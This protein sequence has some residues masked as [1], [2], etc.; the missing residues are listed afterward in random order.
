MSSFPFP[1]DLWEHVLD[2]VAGESTDS[3]RD[4]R[5]CALVNTAWTQRSQERLFQAITLVDNTQRCRLHTLLR[6]TAPHLR[7]FV[8]E[9]ELRRL[10]LTASTG[11]TGALDWTGLLPLV[12]RISFMRSAPDLGFMT[13]LPSLRHVHVALYMGH[14]LKAADFAFLKAAAQSLPSNTGEE[15]QLPHR[16]LRVTFDGDRAETVQQFVLRWVASTATSRARSLRRADLVVGSIQ[17]PTT[18]LQEFLDDNGG[19]TDLGL[20]ITYGASRTVLARGRTC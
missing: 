12:T 2:L 17:G 16:L 20:F 11:D 18:Y 15:E 14:G 4:L 13:Q 7:R 8:H 19:I 5:A 1:Q 6:A 3:K 10:R 9:L